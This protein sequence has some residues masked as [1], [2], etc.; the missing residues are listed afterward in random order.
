MTLAA[1]WLEDC[2]KNHSKCRV[3]QAPLPTRVLYVGPD[4]TDLHLYVSNQEVQRY[5]A[6]SHCWGGSDILTL[7][8]SSL[9][10]FRRSIVF[11]LLPETYKDA[12]TVTRELGIGYLWIDSLCII[13]DSKEDWTKEAVSM[14]EVYAGSFVTIAADRA[15]NSLDGCFGPPLNS[16]AIVFRISSPGQDGTPSFVHVRRKAFRHNDYHGEVAH[17]DGN[18]PVDQYAPRSK[19]DSRAWA[20][21]ERLLAPRVLHYTETEMAW[22]CLTQI[23]CECEI[24]PIVLATPD[25]HMWKYMQ[26]PFY[27]HGLRGPPEA[28]ASRFNWTKLVQEFTSRHLTFQ[29][30]RL[31]ALSGVAS[32]MSSGIAD[33]YLCGLWREDLQMLLCWHV[34]FSHDYEY[35]RVSRRRQ[36]YY[37]PSWSWASVTTP[38]SYSS[39]PENWRE[40]TIDL[41]ILETNCILA[42]TNPYGPVQSGFIKVRGLLAPVTVSNINEI[43]RARS[44]IPDASIQIVSQRASGHPPSLSDEFT[45]DIRGDGYEVSVGDTIFVLLVAFRFGYPFYTDSP[46]DSIFTSS[47]PI[48]PDITHTWQHETYGLALQVSLHNPSVYKR[49]GCLGGSSHRSWDKWCKAATR[50]TL[51]I[52]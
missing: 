46:E 17:P 39:H 47:L 10:A 24:M 21:Q 3:K 33:D 37:A 18:Q 50:E 26:H 38:I 51:T 49:V 41:Q 25:D 44:Q 40:L 34:Y 13:Q 4:S 23:S 14:N 2:T 32:V 12:I 36:S 43:P 6:L 30:D 1:Q 19:L 15:S 16:S 48:M 29:A 35:E 27:K 31:P 8:K 52:I 22:E 28:I 5:A 20:F 9:D 45:P 7:T 42:T 11:E